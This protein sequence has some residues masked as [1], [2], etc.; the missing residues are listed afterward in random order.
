VQLSCSGFDS[1]LRGFSLASFETRY[2]HVFTLDHCDGLSNTQHCSFTRSGIGDL[3]RVFSIGQESIIFPKAIRTI[4]SFP[5]CVNHM[6]DPHI[7]RQSVRKIESKARDKMPFVLSLTMKRF[8]RVHSDSVLQ[9]PCTCQKSRGAS[10]SKHLSR[11]DSPSQPERFKSKRNRTA[12]DSRTE[13]ED[14][15]QQDQIISGAI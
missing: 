15:D 5:R 3:S 2:Y 10:I 8:Q 11:K 14:S 6:K 12:C 9:V 1:L 13:I 7:S 4:R